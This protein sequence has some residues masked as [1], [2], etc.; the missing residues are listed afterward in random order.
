MQRHETES[1]TAYKARRAAANQAVK[2][3]NARVKAGG[4]GPNARSQRPTRAK[5]G[6]K[7]IKG[8]GTVYGATL[9][10]HF[11]SKRWAH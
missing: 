10:A 3:I 11:D 5:V 9:K 6:I 2:M 7:G 8:A 4:S 1:F